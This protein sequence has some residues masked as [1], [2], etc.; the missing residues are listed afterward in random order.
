MMTKTTLT[1]GLL[2]LVGCA[3]NAGGDYFQDAG[4][5]AQD[6]HQDVHQDVQ[7]DAQVEASRDA[8]QEPDVQV[9]DAGQDAQVD[10]SVTGCIF[11]WADGGPV[12]IACSPST[13]V[14]VQTAWNKWEQ[15]AAVGCP[16]GDTCN[17]TVQGVSYWSGH[18]GA[19]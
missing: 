13:S 8:G 17:A 11:P 6:A 15:C 4:Q 3:G 7:V 1:A 10:A 16:D 19:Q 5:D 9:E 18:C 2:M 14:N 12:F